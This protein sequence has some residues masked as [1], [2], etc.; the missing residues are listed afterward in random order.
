MATVANGKP[1]GNGN[2]YAQTIYG[3]MILLVIQALWTVAYSSLQGQLDRQN[4]EFKELRASYLAIREHE[5][6]KIGIR[7]ELDDD[8][9]AL[10]SLQKEEGVRGSTISK[11]DALEK[12]LDTQTARI[13]EVAKSFGGIF[14]PAIKIQ[15]L[16]R[17]IEI[18][19]ER[20]TRPIW[21]PTTPQPAQPPPT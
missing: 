19:Q 16:Q 1:N 6:Y 10:G 18:L 20:L 5:A 15:E 2:G 11:V 21:A 9:L 12:R 7:R 14:T 17:A 8:K 4:A 13:E 3:G